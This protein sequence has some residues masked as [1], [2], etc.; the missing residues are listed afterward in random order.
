MRLTLWYFAV[1]LVTFT[2]FGNGIFFALRASV[3][4]TIDEDLQSRLTGVQRIMERH[5][6]AASL[7]DIRYEFREHSGLR[8]GGDLF[9]VADADRSW[10]FRSVSIRDYDIEPPAGELNKSRYETLELKGTPLRILSAKVKVHGNDYTIQLAAPLAEAYHILGDFRWLLVA[11]IPIV[12]IL[13]SSGGYW[14]SRRALAPVDEITRTARSV[15]EHNLSMRLAIAET[16]DELQRLSETFNQMM[17]RLESAFRRIT[18]FT[19]DASHELRTPVALIR[20]TAELSLRRERNELEYREGLSQIL[21]EAEWMSQLIET[22]MTLARMDCGREALSFETIDIVPVLREACIKSDPLAHL[23]PIH[24]EHSFGPGPILVNA[25]AH[26]LRRLFLILID[27][28][29]K[30][31]MPGG[32]IA[33][34]LQ[35]DA[36]RAVMTVRDT[37]I[38]IANE[39]LPF[40]FERFYRADKARS[41]EAGGAGLGLSI[42]RWIAE[43]HGGSIHVVSTSSEGTTFEVRIPLASSSIESGIS[44]KAVSSQFEQLQRES[45]ES[46]PG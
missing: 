35:S 20:T 16:G 42:G 29:I 18:Q 43:A 28:A 6:P 23:K 10:I 41:R 32:R 36:N 3:H 37:G 5:D 9:Q 27:N 22:L 31:T 17:D 39:D 44:G 19:G 1:F 33:I 7:D 46:R 26:A 12:L 2:A 14:M 8:P 24:F 4:A 34:D 38:G 45:R 40:I 30:Y 15:S 21:E 13:A 11:S 25:D